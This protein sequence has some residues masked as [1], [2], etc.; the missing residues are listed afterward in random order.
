[1][2]KFSGVSKDFDGVRALNNFSLTVAAGELCVLLGSSGCGKSTSLRLVN[3]LLTFDHGEITVN[4]RNIAKY[5]AIQLRRS[6]GYAIQDT[7][8]F[9]HWSVRKN[10]ATVPNLLSWTKERVAARV[11]E[12]LA[13]FGIAEHADKLPHQLSGGQAQR[14]GVA[15]ALAADPD[16]LLM[17][18][19]FAALDPITRQSLQDELLSIQQQL[20]KTIIFV[21]HDID[22]ALKLAD[23][24]V[25][26]SQG[27]IAQ[28][29]APLTLLR[30]PNSQFVAD[31][32]GGN[33][34]GLRLAKF[35][36]VK[37]FAKPRANVPQ[38]AV[39]VPPDTSIEEALSLML[40]NGC[41]YVRV[42]GQQD[43]GC[44]GL[45]DLQHVC[46]R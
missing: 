18:E 19:P 31:F 45:E 38:T 21:T 14:V 5:D 24:L 1:M 32:L 44:V 17:D 36:Q 30:S 40:L 39:T 2:I 27:E 11:D 15:R 20:K 37:Q 3:R 46:Q 42:V 43:Y 4:Y 28:S 12:L 41:Q 8:L 29:G 13:L 33:R 34:R 35:T 22:E 16:V 9:P 26:M 7:G 23:Q 10:I 6:I 25:I